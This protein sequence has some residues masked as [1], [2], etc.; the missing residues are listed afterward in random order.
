MVASL[1]NIERAL[2]IRDGEGPFGSAFTHR[3][4]L[5]ELIKEKS[6]LV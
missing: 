1:V 4:I 6:Q 3:L 5:L 2:G